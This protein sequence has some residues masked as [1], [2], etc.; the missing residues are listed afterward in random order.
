M[1]ATLAFHGLI[2]LNGDF[3]INPGPRVSQV[4]IGISTD[5]SHL[6]IPLQMYH[7]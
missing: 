3:E 1:R 6:L 2:L 4:F 7:F 5:V